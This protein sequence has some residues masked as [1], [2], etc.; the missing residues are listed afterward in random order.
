LLRLGA[1]LAAV[2]LF[3]GDGVVDPLGVVGMTGLPMLPVLTAAAIGAA[4][5][6]SWPKLTA[7]LELGSEANER[8]VRLFVRSQLA[9]GTGWQ[10][11][12]TLLSLLTL[13]TGG[14]LVE[15]GWVYGVTYLPGALIGLF[16]GPL[17]DRLP[18]RALMVGLELGR[19]ASMVALV[20]AGVAG[21]LSMPWLY[22]VA[23]VN[24]IAIQMIMVASRAY[25]PSI[26]EPGEQLRVATGRVETAASTA[27]VAG[28]AL[29]TQVADR[30][31]MWWAVAADPV[32]RLAA[33]I[34]L[35]RISEPQPQTVQVPA[36]P[37]PVDAAGRDRAGGG[38]GA[39]VGRGPGSVGFR[40]AG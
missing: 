25:L 28:P 33:V 14:S 13:A 37:P 7:A 20:A 5:G 9:S 29:G 17:V 21:A 22:A 16:T 24:G 6:A 30:A 36:A 2:L 15:V 31:G 39:G 4:V 34:A 27:L 32:L 8:N 18:G 40:V 1:V 23:A 19:V 38:V 35:L 11:T 26:V 12:A 3:A 10:S